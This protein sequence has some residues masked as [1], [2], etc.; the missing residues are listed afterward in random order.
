MGSPQPLVN[1]VTIRQCLLEFGDARI[2]D[3][4]ADEVEVQQTAQPLKMH[5]PRVCDPGGAEVDLR[6]FGHPLEMYQGSVGDL[7]LDEVERPQNWSA[8]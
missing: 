4:R 2:G 5:Q 8:L 1:D 3:L 6:Q 7:G